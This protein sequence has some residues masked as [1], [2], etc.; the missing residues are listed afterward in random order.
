[1]LHVLRGKMLVLVSERARESG[2]LLGLSAMVFAGGSFASS[3]ARIDQFNVIPSA[4][5]DVFFAVSCPLVERFEPTFRSAFCVFFFQQC[6]TEFSTFW[7]SKELPP[8][9]GGH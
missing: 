2:E 8:S 7:A 1:M 6:D 9:F 5:S 3:P 4:R